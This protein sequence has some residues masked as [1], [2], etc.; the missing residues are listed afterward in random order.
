ML[1]KKKKKAQV[2]NYCCSV[3]GEKNLG[4]LTRESDEWLLS[5]EVVVDCLRQRRACTASQK[6]TCQLQPEPQF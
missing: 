5:L 3:T 6:E 1:L 4:I 2:E